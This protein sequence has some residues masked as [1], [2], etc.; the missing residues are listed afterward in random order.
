MT[1]ATRGEESPGHPSVV[2]NRRWRSRLFRFISLAVSAAVALWA[3]DFGLLLWEAY[4]H[5]NLIQRVLR[6]KEEPLREEYGCS[7][8][9]MHEACGPTPR[10]TSDEW[11]LYALDQSAQRIPLTRLVE[12]PWAMHYAYNDIGLRD[13]NYG[14]QP[15]P[16][17]VRILGLGDSFAFGHSVPDEETLFRQMSA[18][19][20]A[21]Y[22]VINAAKSG[23]YTVDELAQ[24]QRL[25]PFYHP[26]AV[27]VVWIPNDISVNADLEQELRRL[28]A[29]RIEVEQ[30]TGG[31]RRL[32]R[33]GRWALE[34]DYNLFQAQCYDPQVNQWGLE[35]FDRTLSEFAALPNCT[36]AF[37]LYPML[38]RSLGGD[39]LLADVHRRVADMI[40][41]HQIPVLDLA[42]EF[43]GQ[44]AADLRV[45]DRDHHP[46]ARANKIAARAIVD[47]IRTGEAGFKAPGLAPAPSR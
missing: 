19:L 11:R 7:N 44:N 15:A 46:N 23:M 39:Y 24:A 18:D 3:C 31:I 35:L 45:H 9:K 41:R 38:D 17:V 26:H 20:G 47:W 43:A 16:G 2:P 22:E 36:V 5:P 32:I 34:R 10:F 6:R 8:V 12:T 1:D 28:M 14:P 42:P 4:A 33:G 21:G 40:R 25:L 27:L 30:K 37:V 29:N 13:R